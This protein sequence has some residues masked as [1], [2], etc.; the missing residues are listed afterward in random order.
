[1]T[2]L[3]MWVKNPIISYH[4]DNSLV[5]VEYETETDMLLAFTHLKNY[6]EGFILLRVDTEIIC[7]KNDV[8]IVEY[9]I[10]CKTVY[11]EQHKDTNQASWHAVILVME[12]KN[13]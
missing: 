2:I 10:E 8:K 5:G 3:S 13:D 11:A 4:E 9:K 6:G 12:G 1:M 7:T